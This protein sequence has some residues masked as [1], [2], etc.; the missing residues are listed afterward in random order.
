M[1]FL[2]TVGL[3]TYYSARRISKALRNWR[4]F[5][6][7]IFGS[8]IV[9]ATSGLPLIDAYQVQAVPK[10]T[11]LY[12]N[13]S[14]A[15]VEEGGSQQFTYRAEDQDHNPIKVRS[16]W[17]M[18]K[19]DAGTINS[20]GNF[21]AS[22][23]PGTYTN[24]VKLSA[25]ALS[26]YA[27][28]IVYKTDTPPPVDNPKL[29][30]L[31]IN[32]STASV[33]EGGSQQFTYR[34]EDQDHN[35]IK[36][37]S[38]W[39]MNKSDAGTINS[40]GN[41]TASNIP[42]TYTNAVKL[43]AGALSTYARVIVYKTPVIQPVLNRVEVVP[44]SIVLD[45]SSSYQFN[46]RAYDQ[47]NNL[48]TSGVSYSWAVVNNGGTIASNGTFSAGSNDGTFADTVRVRATMNSNIVYDYATV[49]VNPIIIQA[50]LDRVE[51]LDTNNN[52]LTSF[53]I[54]EGASKQFRAVAY[55]TDGRDVTTTTDLIWDTNSSAGII[56]SNGYFTASSNAGFYSEAI[57][58][59]GTHKG[60]TKL[61]TVSALINEIQI[62]T[63][64]NR[65]EVVPSSIVLDQSSSYQF[66]ARAYDQDNN[67]LTSGVS[68]SWAV[69]NN[70]GTIASNGTFSAGSN[71]G[72]FADTVRVRA[73]MNSNIVYDYATVIVNPIIIQATLDRV[74]ILPSS[75]SLSPYQVFDFDAQA[76]DTNNSPIF[77]DLTYSWN[78]ISGPGTVNENGLF[79]SSSNGIATIQVLASAGGIHRY[80]TATVNI[81][82][83]VVTG[84]LHSVVIDPQIIYLEQGS[85]ADFD[86]QAYD[87]NSNSVY[88]TYTWTSTNNTAGSVSQNGYFTAGY[89][90][91][92][93]YNA[94]RVKAYRN[95]VERYDY[96]DVI[97]RNSGGNNDTFNINA[98]LHVE[99]ENGGEAYPL[100]VLHYTLTLTNQT[101]SGTA[102]R[103][104]N[105]RS[106]FNLPD[107][108]TFVS[109]TSQI[110]GAGINSRT[111]VWEAGTLQYGQSKTLNLRV[112]INNNVPKGRIISAKAYVNADQLNNGLW[113]YANDIAVVGGTTNDEPLT[114]TGALQWL[115]AGIIA[116]LATV[117]T[118][119]LL[120]TKQLLNY[121]I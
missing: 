11:Y 115:L 74:E 17:S 109:V 120:R 39:S 87:I 47:D 108:V 84:D 37:R 16:S 66:N 92:T 57:S 65:V 4:K 1:Y 46:A 114:P 25:G 72:T 60:Q 99:D 86:A 89:T 24:A 51:I 93:Y 97:V 64:L 3:R 121:R 43:S 103:L 40:S 101:S 21:T 34:A 68:Y 10:L 116:M 63:T 73:T 2:K 58:L 110:G 48:L 29:T 44:S 19:S 56:N 82:G 90:I 50:T 7:I 45:Q 98:N 26:T 41:F 104:Y 14:T 105:V 76:Y 83:G 106:T 61:D 79:E 20:S 107:Y 5:G 36:V 91:G 111:I 12:I 35:P 6:I 31:Y 52:A 59:T 55:D 119:Q 54:D 81:G 94:V 27:R 32:P 117:L 38:S 62:P 95:G 42:G 22:N 118:R 75:I 28:V 100:D 33:E 112:R 49:I 69:V 88:A 96:A 8:F 67:L 85:S 80:D 77:N 23:I 18:N 102:G 53:N 71:D 70:G 9:A 15:S 13:P 113:V 30:Y 78:V